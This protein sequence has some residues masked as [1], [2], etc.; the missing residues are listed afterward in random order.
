MKFERFIFLSVLV[1]AVFQVFINA[2]T[3]V[4]NQV[5]FTTPDAPWTLVIDGQAVDIKTAQVKPDNKSAYFLVYPNKDGLNI[6]LFIEPVDKCKTSDECRDFVLNSGNPAWGKFQ[7]LAKA[8]IGEFSY[9]EFYRPE[10]M[11][12][13]LQMQDMYAQYVGSG[14]WVDLHISKVDYKKTDHLLF[15]NLV[16]S[17]K[18]VPKTNAASDKNLS[19]IQAAVEKWLAV[20]DAG[21]CKESFAA[22]SPISRTKI[23]EKLWVDYCGSAHIGLGKL[24][25]RKVIASTTVT[26]LP[27]TPDRPGA[28]VRYQSVFENSPVVEFV[29]LVLEKDGSWTV[30]NYLTQ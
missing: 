22:L 25:S 17:V 19:A 29:S 30:A 21:K 11:G 3:V 26:S 23:S 7:D 28:T 16:K 2:Q 27:P 12:Q 18:F 6:S 10:A 1:L 5:R 14:Y 9:F 20:W 13:P 8:R 15:E 24:K 4:P